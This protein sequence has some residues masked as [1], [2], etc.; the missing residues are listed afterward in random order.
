[1]TK[2]ILMPNG[3]KLFYMT[4]LEN[5]ERQVNQLGTTVDLLELCLQSI[6]ALG[7]RRIV[8]TCSMHTAMLHPGVLTLSEP[9]YAGM[10]QCLL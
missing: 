1:M 2:V 7:L 10:Y 4:Q 5:P 3:T 6:G 9:A 8:A